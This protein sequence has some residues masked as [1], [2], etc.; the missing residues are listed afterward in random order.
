MAREGS[1]EWVADWLNSYVIKNHP[2]TESVR[3]DWM[4]SKDAMTARAGWSPGGLN[5]VA[6]LDRRRTGDLPRLPG[7]EA[8]YLAIRSHLDPKDG[9]PA[10]GVRP[11]PTAGARRGLDP[12]GPPQ[13]PA[14]ALHLDPA[15]SE[16]DGSRTRIRT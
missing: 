15:R 10:V 16:K 5:L 7:A 3:E 2:D 12:A 8:P 14:A 4:A 9:E 13:A 1:C 11:R 6:L